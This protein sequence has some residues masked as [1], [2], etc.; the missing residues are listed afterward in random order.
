MSGDPIFSLLL[1]FALG[2]LS[3]KGTWKLQF[4]KGWSDIDGGGL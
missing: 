1:G 3:S 2:L 4:W